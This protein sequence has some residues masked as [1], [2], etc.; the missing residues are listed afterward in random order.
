MGVERELASRKITEGKPKVRQGEVGMFNWTHPLLEERQG[1]ATAQLQYVIHR[2]AALHTNS[3]N[4]HNSATHMCVNIP[5]LQMGKMRLKGVKKP[6]YWY[7]LKPGLKPKLWSEKGKTS[8]YFF[9]HA[10]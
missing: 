5:I 10:T 7:M 2:L 1:T 9:Y 4:P 8:L 6:S 3:F